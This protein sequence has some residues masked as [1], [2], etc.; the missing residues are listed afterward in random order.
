MAPLRRQEDRSVDSRVTWGGSM[1]S[2]GVALQRGGASGQGS[3]PSGAQK[4]FSENIS[5][6]LHF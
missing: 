2:F 4:E 5:E 3:Q 6:L 1:C